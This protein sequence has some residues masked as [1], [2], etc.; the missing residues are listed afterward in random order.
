VGPVKVIGAMTSAV[1]LME[2]G[3]PSENS[4]VQIQ[5]EKIATWSVLPSSRVN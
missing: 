3:E 1:T 4:Q 5:G 2:S